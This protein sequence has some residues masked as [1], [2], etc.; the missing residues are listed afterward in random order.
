MR[1]RHDTDH[2]RAAVRVAEIRDDAP[3]LLEE[4]AF[5]LLDA[6]QLRHLADDDRQRESDDEALE[7]RLGDEVGEEAET[8]QP[9][10]QREHAGHD[11]ER[12]VK[13]AK[14]S[15]VA[16]PARDVAESAAVADIGPVTR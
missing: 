11:R 9:G 4:V 7:H 15:P 3:Q 6:E 2:Q 12:R 14:L 8:Q 13:A 1:E 16:M 5:L 10:G